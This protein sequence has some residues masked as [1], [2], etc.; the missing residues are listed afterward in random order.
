MKSKAAEMEWQNH[1]GNSNYFIYTKD[2]F[3]GSASTQ[4][5]EWSCAHMLLAKHALSYTATKGTAPEH[6][7]L[8]QELGLKSSCTELMWERLQS[9]VFLRLQIQQLPAC[10]ETSIEHQQHFTTPRNYSCL[11]PVEI[12]SDKMLACAGLSAWMASDFS[13]TCFYFSAERSESQ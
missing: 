1:E 3:C 2:N 5:A 7:L 6:Q 10:H 12:T 4:R 11:F 8:L 13:K 9:F